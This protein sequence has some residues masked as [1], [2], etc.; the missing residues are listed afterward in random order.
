MRFEMKG[1]DEI[2]KKL[3]DLEVRAKQM[4]GEHKIPVNEV[5]TVEFMRQHTKF[6]SF[7]EMI[8]AS[9]QKVESA[10]DFDAIPDDVWDDFVRTTTEFKSWEAM[11]G[12]AGALWAQKKMGLD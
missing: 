11:L 8:E 6:G 2:Q 3:H 9:G 1:L 7:D 4:R 10:E 12:A 5:L